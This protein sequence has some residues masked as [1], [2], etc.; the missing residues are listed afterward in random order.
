MLRRTAALLA[1]VAAPC[2]VR[3]AD[4]AAVSLEKFQRVEVAP[5]KTS[6]Y[7]G[8][9]AMTMPVFTRADGAYRS[10]YAAKVFPYFF[11]NETGRLSIDLPD[12]KLLAL[13]R[14]EPVEFVGHAV[15][16]DGDERRITGKAT[17]TD[18]TTGKLKVR[19]LVSKRIE[20]IFNTT[21][22]FLPPA[23]GAEK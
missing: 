8:S 9:V 21:Y 7:V 14:G 5:T 12:D 4:P 20:L 1:F 15:N 10:T 17:P 22:R 16:H 6:I 2:L 13:E 11:S 3:G 18:A 23:A 19:V